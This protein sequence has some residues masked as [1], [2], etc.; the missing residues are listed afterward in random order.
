MAFVTYGSLEALETYDV[1]QTVTEEII[2]VTL[3]NAPE[4]VSQI[5]SFFKITNGR[6]PDDKYVASFNG[7][8]PALKEGELVAFADDKT[9]DRFKITKIETVEKNGEVYTNVHYRNISDSEK[10]IEAESDTPVY[11]VQ[12]T[13]TSTGEASFKK[14]D[15]EYNFDDYNKYEHNVLDYNFFSE[16]KDTI[17]FANPTAKLKFFAKTPGEWGNSLKI[18]IAKPEDFENN[19]FV[20]EGI[21]LD[22]VLQY[23]PAKGHFV[24]VVLFEEEVVE[25]FDCSFDETEKNDRGEFTFVETV[26][27]NKS[28]YILVA[29][30]ENLPAEI[31]SCLLCVD[32]NGEYYVAPTDNDLVRLECGELAQIGP[33]DLESAYDTFSNKEEVVI[34][35]IIANELNYRPAVKL[36]QTRQDCL[37]ILSAPKSEI[38]GFKAQQAADNIVKWKK[39]LNISDMFVAVYSNYKYQYS[40][41]LGKFIWVS[42]NGDIAGIIS[43]TVNNSGYGFAPAGLNRGNI[44]NIQKLAFISTQGIS[45]EFYKNGINPVTGFA[46][47]G[48]ILNGQKTSLMRPSSFDRVNVVMLLNHMSRVLGNMSR[49]SLFEFNDAFTRNQIIST[50]KPF[51]QELKASRALSDFMLICDEQNNTKQVIANNWLVVDIYFKPAYAAEFIRLNF[52]NYGVNDF[53]ISYS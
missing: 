50:M 46:D 45:D 34:D 49:Y 5:A 10:L 16:I 36:A 12:R 20:N 1:P 35:T 42:L 51:L 27:N 13:Q 30:N 47:S 43:D 21:G 37:A 9:A 39:N 23:I 53:T 26:I 4:N 28:D 14:L 22:N 19:K 33:D 44:K 29:S 18:A 38:I 7:Y 25:T 48:L 24:V 6:Q 11:K 41:E 40:S 8:D 15:E 32:V 2:A 17:A 31:C 52:N 3:S